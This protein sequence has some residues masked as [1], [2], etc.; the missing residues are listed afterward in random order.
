MSDYKRWYDEDPVVAECV[1]LLESTEDSAKRK[2]ATFLMDEIVSKSPYIE[3]LP[4]TILELVNSES[5]RRRWYDFDEVIRIFIELL[6]NAPIETKKK[7]A[8]LAIT[9]IQDLNTTESI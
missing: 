6:N 8:I 7:I 9:F 4:E 1:K 3:M 5:Q 2:T